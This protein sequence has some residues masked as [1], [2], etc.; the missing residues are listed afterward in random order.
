MSRA[1]TINTRLREVGHAGVDVHGDGLAGLD[2]NTLET[3]QLLQRN[4]IGAYYETIG[5]SIACWSV[6]PIA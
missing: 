1:H 5:L 3:E 4:A 2:E 6:L